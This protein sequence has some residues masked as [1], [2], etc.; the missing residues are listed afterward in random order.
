MLIQDKLMTEYGNL[1]DVTEKF[2][3][4]SLSKESH[5]KELNLIRKRTIKLYDEVDGSDANKLGVLG[6]ILYN[7]VTLTQKKSTTI[8]SIAK[9]VGTQTN[10]HFKPTYI[11]RQISSVKKFFG[12]GDYDEVYK[13]LKNK[14]PVLYPYSKKSS[15]Q[16]RTETT[17]FVEH[18]YDKELVQEIIALIQKNNELIEKLISKVM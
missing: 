11:A 12:S 7:I 9:I 13:S 8:K 4:G 16:T 1:R 6:F 17:T 10:S 14:S 15:E 2:N 3:V 18:I 5:I